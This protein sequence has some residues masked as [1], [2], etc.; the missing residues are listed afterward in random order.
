MSCTNFVVKD[1]HGS[2]E[3]TCDSGPLSSLL[4]LISRQG[5]RS[6]SFFE[7]EE[8]LQTRASSVF[9]W[10]KNRLSRIMQLHESAE[11]S[12]SDSVCVSQVS[13]EQSTLHVIQSPCLKSLE[14]LAGLKLVSWEGFVRVRQI[15]FPW[16]Q[17]FSEIFCLCCLSCGRALEKAQDGVYAPCRFCPIPYKDE[18]LEAV[19]AFREAILTLE[20][21]CSNHEQIDE[22]GIY[23]LDVWA[24]SDI[25]R[26]ILGITTSANAQ[27]LQ[28]LC[29]ALVRPEN[30][31]FHV[32]IE[33]R[34][35]NGTIKLHVSKFTF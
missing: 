19:W 8:E 18:E 27:D 22:A 30:S 16:I 17:S 25:V 31:P 32:H 15:R 35:T 21:G 33:S 20:D 6:R 34:D 1:F 5:K 24:D 9:E 28:S 14:T 2:R 11:S 13:V 10:S 3:I 23:V 7:L 4:L 26:Q 29:E 12:L